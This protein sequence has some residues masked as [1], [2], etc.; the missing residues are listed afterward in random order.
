MTP[1]E[2]VARSDHPQWCAGTPTNPIFGVNYETMPAPVGQATGISSVDR[3]KGL[4]AP[5]GKPAAYELQAQQLSAFDATRGELFV[6]GFNASSKVP[7]VVGLDVTTGAIDHETNVKWLLELPFVGLGQSIDVD[8]ATGDLIVSG[9][10]PTNESIT[11]VAR[12][13]RASKFQNHAVLATVVSAN[14]PPLFVLGG[15]STLD[16]IN[17]IEYLQG[18]VN[19][20]KTKQIYMILI[21]VDL[22]TGK[23]TTIPQMAVM[24]VMILQKT[25]VD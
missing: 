8:P 6:F 15:S 25:F 23:Y 17:G 18:G 24:P 21:A 16:Y 9:P 12:I 2:C 7:N 13:T 19:D 20:T 10:A 1:G 11:L 14:D 3:I 22:K 4:M 5:I